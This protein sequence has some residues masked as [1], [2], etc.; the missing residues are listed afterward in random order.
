MNAFDLYE[1]QQQQQQ[2]FQQHQHFQSA[3]PKSPPRMSVSDNAINFE[4]Y[5]EETDMMQTEGS[6]LRGGEIFAEK[7]EINQLE[8]L[9]PVDSSFLHEQHDSSNSASFSADSFSGVQSIHDDLVKN[10]NDDICGSIPDI[11]LNTFSPNSHTLSTVDEETATAQQ[12]N[13]FLKAL[14]NSIARALHGDSV[15]TAPILYKGFPWLGAITVKAGSLRGNL[16]V[17]HRTY[18]VQARVLAGGHVLPWCIGRDWRYSELRKLLVDDFQATLKR[19]GLQSEFTML[20]P[21]S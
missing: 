18:T 20:A 7:Q 10:H 3:G 9:A 11:I 17:R 5:D 13:A 16:V 6:D 19:Y 2:Q 21:V 12:G 1:Q 14:V 8:S 15:V 4:Q